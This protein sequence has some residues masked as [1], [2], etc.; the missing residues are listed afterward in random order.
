VKY[1]WVINEEELTHTVWKTDF[2]LL[3]VRDQ[4]Q[5]YIQ[6]ETKSLARAIK[7]M[8]KNANASILEK[9]IRL[10]RIEFDF[11]QGKELGLHQ[12]Q[13]GIRGLVNQDRRGSYTSSVCSICGM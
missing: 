3:Y 7:D 10:I 9:K 13:D 8:Q 4:L 6:N 5:W 11:V 2:C 12:I 1:A